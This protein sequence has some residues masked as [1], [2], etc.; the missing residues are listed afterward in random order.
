MNGT[1]SASAGSIVLT[2]VNSG[3]GK[4]SNFNFGAFLRAASSDNSF[5]VWLLCV[6]RTRS[7][8]SR[9]CAANFGLCSAL[10]K[11]L[12]TGTARLASRTWTTGWLKFGAIFT[13]VCALL[14]VAPPMSS[15]SVRP[16]RSISRATWTISSSDGVISPLKPMMSTFS[17]I[18][19]CKIFS[20]GTMTPRSMIS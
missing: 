12:A 8:S 7:Y 2:P 15:G 4:S 9:I 11:L 3:F 5:A 18:A 20:H 16:L 1:S 6:A 13:A 14:V 10:I 19:V 17:S